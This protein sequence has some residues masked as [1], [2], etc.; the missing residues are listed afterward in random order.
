MQH[1]FFDSAERHQVGLPLTRLLREFQNESMLRTPVG[2]PI[3]S[4]TP[5][6]IAVSITAEIIGI[7]NGAID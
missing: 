5:E 3:G 7:R 2:V 6:E 4:H 1:G